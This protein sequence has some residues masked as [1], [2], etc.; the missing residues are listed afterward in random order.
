MWVPSLVPAAAPVS[1]KC[2][3]EIPADSVCLKKL[4]EGCF[5]FISLLSQPLEKERESL[6]AKV[7]KPVPQQE[8]IY[9]NV[10]STHRPSEEL[11]GTV[12]GT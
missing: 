11:Y 12:W 7:Q 10:P 8:Q 3:K 4:H 5:L 1:L 2:H 6:Y 9:A